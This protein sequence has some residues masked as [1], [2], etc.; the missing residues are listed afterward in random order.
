MKYTHKE[1][2][3][4]KY[5]SAE[6]IDIVKLRSDNDTCSCIPQNTGTQWRESKASLWMWITSRS[7]CCRTGKG[8]ECFWLTPVDLACC[9]NEKP[10]CREWNPVASQVSHLPASR[11]LASISQILLQLKGAV[12]AVSSCWLSKEQVLSQLPCQLGDT[13]STQYRANSYSLVIVFSVTF[14]LS[15][16]KPLTIPGR[17]LAAYWSQSVVYSFQVHVPIICISNILTGY[18]KGNVTQS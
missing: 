13:D 15:S 4:L 18:R 14:N 8:P 17:I 12:W 1:T 2:L 11:V 6:M 3:W 16:V 7:S 9:R 10:V 5:F